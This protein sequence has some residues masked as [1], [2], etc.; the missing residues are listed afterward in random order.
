MSAGPRSERSE[1][2][3]VQARHWEQADT[4]RFRWVTEDPYPAR[5]EAALLEPVR[6]VGRFLE[7]GCGEG[8]NLFHLGGA[9][10]SFHGM[11]RFRAKLVFARAR[12]PALQ[13]AVADA[14]RLPY[15]SGCF[16]GVLVRDL[17]HHVFD[18]DAVLAEAW[19]VLRPGGALTLIEPNV[20]SPLILAQALTT[21]AERGLL[22]ST[23]RRLRAELER[24]P[25]RG[26]VELTLAHPLPLERIVLHPRL[27]WPGL[28]RLAPVRG[29]F[30]ALEWLAPRA[31]PRGAW[32]YVRAQVVKREAAGR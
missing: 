16:D 4:V 32:A 19:R 21:P 31:V 25:G 26:P 28:W 7:V 13:A 17:L 24:L 14:E 23:P 1:H 5:T 11:D 15:R 18:R 12:Q 10:A 8:G 29:A 27:G 2:E 30:R 3:Q 20:R 22:R 9:A 6:P